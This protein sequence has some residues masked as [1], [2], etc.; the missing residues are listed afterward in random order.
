MKKRSSLFSILIGATTVAV[1][2][3]GCTAGGAEPGAEERDPIRLTT[4][5]APS[6]FPVWLA[7]ELGFY[8]ENGLDV[9]EMSYFPSGAPMLEAGLAGEWDAGY[10][11]GPPAIV[12]G[13]R[14]GMITGG[15]EA[16]ESGIHAIY[17]RAGAG[18]DDLAGG[19][20]LLATGS[21]GH[22]VLEACLEENGT[23]LDEMQAVSLEMP[24]IVST[25]ERGEGDLAQVWDPF[26]VRMDE[27]FERL[28]SGDELGVDVFVVYQL[29]PDFVESNRDAAVRWL[30]AVYRANEMMSTDVDEVMP[31][32]R[33]FLDE[34]GVEID[35]PS[36]E[37]AISG[38]NWM[39]LEEAAEL[40][41]SGGT[42]DGL[43]ATAEFLSSIGNLDEVPE[44]DFIDTELLNEALEYRAS[45]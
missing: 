17:Q 10:I 44:F 26:L 35:D 41:N 34:Q 8:E 24:N 27:Q 3:S 16:E 14:W 5:P 4:M 37:L 15:V 30:E 40:N 23:S 19:T 7:G 22:Q 2:L 28:C 25:F 11:G 31:L 43:R 32:I 18:A 45:K 36:L 33:E 1:A 39:S 38:R 12:G 6:G 29:H 42:E 9:Q 20:A 21:T 13:A